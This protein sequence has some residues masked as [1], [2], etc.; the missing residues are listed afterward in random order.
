MYRVIRQSVSVE[1]VQP[2]VMAEEVMFNG[3]TSTFRDT[4]KPR[5]NQDGSETCPLWRSARISEVH[6][7]SRAW[8]LQP[9]SSAHKGLV[10]KF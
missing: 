2:M 5:P 8:Q 6:A 1:V 10:L 7:S 4:S 3:Q 9:L